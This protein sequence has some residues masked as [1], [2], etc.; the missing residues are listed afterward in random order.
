MWSD[1]QISK[2]LGIAYPIIQG[3]FGCGL[4]S[5]SLAA[6]VSRAGGL[7]SYGANTLAPAQIKDIAAEIRA[8]TDKPFALH[9]WVDQDQGAAPTLG[10]ERFERMRSWFVPYYREL[11]I[12]PPAFPKQIGQDFEAQ[13]EA[14][15][16]ARPHVFSF[17]FGIPS[18]EILKE[19]RSRGIV[20]IGTATALDEARALEQAEV[21]AIVAVGF[22]AGGHAGAFLH[23]SG[24]S[25]IGSLALVPQVVDAVKLPV[26]AAGGIA[27][28]RGIVA[29]LA[30]GAQAVQ[31]GTAFLAC[32]QSGAPA[33]HRD[34]L[35]SDAAKD[36]ALSRVFSGRLARGI[37][38]RL[39]DEMSARVSDPL[40][41][42][43]QNWF[44]D[45]FRKA[46]IERGRSDLM[47]LEAGQIAPLIRHRDA[48]ALM[49]QLVRETPRILARLSR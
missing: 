18:P 40:P 30:L 13:V 1:T 4:S 44:T 9:L 17:A 47:S 39:M 46:A 15:L 20:T 49:A 5:V 14:L 29:A 33:E 27:D 24:K 25:L 38:N 22:E 21:D 43:L 42:P 7:G 3:P 12:A 8:R 34:K 35:F 23:A 6:T 32:D 2:R 16:T 41:Y 10:K 48:A 45:T 37:R 28:A 36:T 26:V 11:G 19:C 31:I